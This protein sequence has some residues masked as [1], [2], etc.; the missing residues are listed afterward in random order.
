M[1][2]IG[3]IADSIIIPPLGMIILKWRDDYIL[4]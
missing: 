1:G 2:D 3:D 4:F